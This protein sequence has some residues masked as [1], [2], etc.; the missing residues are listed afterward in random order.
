MPQGAPRLDR[1]PG[2]REM[3]QSTL[4]EKVGADGIAVDRDVHEL[5][6]QLWA[7]LT[8]NLTGNQKKTH[9]AVRQDAVLGS[10]GLDV[11]R[12]VVCQLVSKSEER[13]HELYDAVIH[14]KA[15]EVRRGDGRR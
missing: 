10:H 11:W 6:H 9:Q 3:D 2:D 1:D 14:P 8:L 5:S 15:P 4:A 12:K 7:F 13:R